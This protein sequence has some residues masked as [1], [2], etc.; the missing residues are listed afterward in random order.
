MTAGATLMLKRA[1]FSRNAEFRCVFMKKG[2][3]TQQNPV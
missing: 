3:A 2:G 1:N